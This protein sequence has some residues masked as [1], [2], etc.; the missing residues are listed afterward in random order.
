MGSMCS[1]LKIYYQDELIDTCQEERCLV[2]V[3]LNDSPSPVTYTLL[4]A[5]EKDD[6]LFVVNQSAEAFPLSLLSLGNGDTA[7]N[8]TEWN[9]DL[10]APG[11]CVTAWKDSGKPKT[12]DVTCNEVGPRLTRKGEERFWKSSFAVSFRGE[13]VITCEDA[14]CL[15][16]IVE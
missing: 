4:I 6:S 11:E 7:I 1:A 14:T 8:G 13:L 3:M 16:E 2:P 5:T 9:L 12:P 15:I 10:L